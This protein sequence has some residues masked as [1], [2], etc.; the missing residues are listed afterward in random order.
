MRRWG[1]FFCVF[2]FLVALPHM[3]L[4]DAAPP[5][6][7]PGSS[8]APGSVDTQVRM[9]EETVLI[10]ILSDTPP[11]SAGKARV[12]ADFTM[13]NMGDQPESMAVRF[14]LGR[15]QGIKGL[16]A[17]DDIVVKVNNSIGPMRIIEDKGDDLYF[18][19]I[20]DMPWATFDVTFP[21]DQDVSIQVTYSLEA[22]AEKPFIKFDYI[23][24]TGAG[25]K[26]SIG[27][28]TLIVNFPY[29][30][31]DLNVLPDYS[32]ESD[33]LSHRSGP[34]QLTWIFSNFEPQ[35]TDN[36]EINLVAPSTWK[37]ILLERSNVEK[38]PEDG[39]AW[40]RLGKLYKE[41]AF[42]PRGKGF[43]LS[44][45]TGDPGGR[46]LIMLSNEAYQKAVALKPDDPLWH[47]GFADLL[48]YYSFWAG[49]FECLDTRQEAEKALEQI[50]LALTLAPQDPLVQSIAEELQSELNDEIIKVNDSYQFPG[51]TATP[52]L[53]FPTWCESTNT[54]EPITTPTVL[55]SFPEQPTK[56]IPTA[57][58]PTPL[59]P[60]STGFPICGS[61]ILIPFGLLLL[62]RKKNKYL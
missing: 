24:A 49:Q 5:S 33:P 27:K 9:T 51:L 3:V 16:K 43:R 60:N 29:L 11:D 25:W 47:A 14:P 32:M 1:L 28:A 22:S 54:P 6:Q 19:I 46:A 45:I 34:S 10:D 8:L 20:E 41:I 62:I 53:S 21:K 4:A 7:P 57:S 12:T 13:H 55:A 18:G 17:I 30:I 26:G 42:S 52:E 44:E 35:A 31:N 50:Q 36:F 58:M 38:N 39:E 48:G 15:V 61:L 40:G 2:V 23:F 56:E 37:D 59:K